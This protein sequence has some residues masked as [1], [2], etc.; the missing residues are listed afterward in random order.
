LIISMKD[1]PPQGLKQIRAFLNAS[2]ELSFQA[3]DRRELYEWINQT[4]RQQDYGSLKREGRG[5]VRRYPAKMTGLSRAQVARLI[6]CYQQG[7]EVKPRLYRRHR[8]PS[9]YTRADIERLAAVD[10]AHET[11]SGPATQK[12]LQRELHEFHNA[13]YERLARLSVLSYTG[14]AKAGPTVTVVSPISR[15]SPHRWRSESGAS[16]IHRT[17]R[18]ICAWTPCIQAT[19]TERRA[20]IT[21]TRSMK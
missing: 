4:L 15:R 10:Q 3:R 17:G 6:R 14:C 2:R 7:G 11:L 20:C 16:P 19:G 1:G 12:I 18:D 8:F 21:S 9:V 5:L 13:V